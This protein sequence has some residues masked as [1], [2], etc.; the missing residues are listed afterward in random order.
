MRSNRSTNGRRGR[1]Q[2]QCLILLV[3]GKLAGQCHSKICTVKVRH[4]GLI[5]FSFPATEGTTQ[6]RR[7]RRT[8]TT[9]PAIVRPLWS[10][11]KLRL[12][13]Y[14]G[15]HGLKEVPLKPR[16]DNIIQLSHRDCYTEQAL[17]RVRLS[18]KDKAWNQARTQHVRAWPLERAERSKGRRTRTPTRTGPAH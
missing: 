12:W 5:D 16:N 13:H 17:L 15:C 9:V 14:L 18:Q 1:D 8:E 11:H 7:L 10:V 4:G 6:G 3:L 2:A